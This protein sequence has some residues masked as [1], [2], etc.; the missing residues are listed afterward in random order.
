MV[1]D[2]SRFWCRFFSFARTARFPHRSNS[3]AEDGRELLRLDL[4]PK[5]A[6]CF[7]AQV[8][9]IHGRLT[10]HSASKSAAVL[11]VDDHLD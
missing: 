3:T 11:S 6:A 4:H 9:L 2:G 10:A 5:A 7:F 1:V 8:A